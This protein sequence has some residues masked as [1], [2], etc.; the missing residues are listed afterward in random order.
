MA[1]LLPAVGGEILRLSAIASPSISLARR[2]KM[3]VNRAMTTRRAHPFQASLPMQARHHRAKMITFSFTTIRKYLPMPSSKSCQSRNDCCESKHWRMEQLA[4][5]CQIAYRTISA[6][7]L[8][9]KTL[10]RFQPYVPAIGLKNVQHTTA[11]TAGVLFLRTESET[12]AAAER[13]QSK[14][15]ESFQHTIADARNQLND[16]WLKAIS[17]GSA[18]FKNHRCKN[19]CPG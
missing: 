18:R 16:C 19:H 4:A 10:Y 11:M 3:L 9:N 6:R 12:V 17:K 15:F 2:C 5:W 1:G 8:A 13:D 7:D 14:T